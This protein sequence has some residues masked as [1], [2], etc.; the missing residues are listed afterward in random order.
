LFVE[1]FLKKNKDIPVGNLR[2]LVEAFD[3]LKDPTL[4]LKRSLVRRG[5]EAMI[6]LIMSHGEDVDWAKVSSSHARGPEEMKEFFT[7]AKK[8]SQNLVSQILLAPTYSTAA[9]SLSVP[10]VTYPAPTEVAYTSVSL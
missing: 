6:A 4:S 8:Y 1:L 3:T 7:E 5:A 10:P 9:P 2:Q